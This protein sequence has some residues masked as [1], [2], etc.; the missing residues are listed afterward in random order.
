MGGLAQ[1]T[2]DV[3]DRELTHSPALG[4]VASSQAASMG[5]G[6]TT[7]TYDGGSNSIGHPTHVQLPFGTIDYTYDVRDRVATETRMLSAP[8]AIAG[9][10]QTVTRTYNV[11]GAPVTETWDDGTAWSYAYDAR[12]LLAGAYYGGTTLASYT[13][14][15]AGPPRYRTSTFDQRRDWSYDVLGRVTY[16]RIWRPTA[17][18]SWAERTYGFDGIGR[19][20]AIAGQVNGTT[21]DASYDYDLRDR[22]ISAQGPS[23]YGGTFTYSPAGNVNSATVSGA[24]DAPTRDVTYQYG[25]VDPQAV[26]ALVDAKTGSL[27]AS[28]QYDANGNLISRTGSGALSSVVSD[29]DDLIR[30]ASGPGGTETYFFGANAERMVAISP[31]EIKVWFGE[32]ETHYSLAGVQTLRWY[33]VA[34]GEPIARL[35]KT[36]SSISIELQYADALQNLIMSVTSTSQVSSSFLYGAFG[37]VVAQTGSGNHRR[38]F[39]GKEADATTG[40]RAYGYRSYDPLLLRWTAADPM[41]RFAPDAAW[42]QPQRAN[43]YAFSLN[44][45]VRYVDPDGRDPDSLVLRALEF[46]TKNGASASWFSYV[47]TYFSLNLVGLVAWHDVADEIHEGRALTNDVDHMGILGHVL[48]SMTSNLEKR[49]AALPWYPIKTDDKTGSVVIS[50]KEISDTE[51][52]HDKAASIANDA[53]ELRG[54]IH[55]IEAQYTSVTD[56]ALDDDGITRA[57][58]VEA[59]TVLEMSFSSSG[60]FLG[61]LKAMDQRASTVQSDARRKQYDAAYIVGYWYPD[62]F[63]PSDPCPAEPCP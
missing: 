54:Q 4:D 51:A 42:A 41:Y 1:N 23:A 7:T 63:S 30:R 24:L 20:D 29:G 8:S 46:L 43:L 60:G 16:D 50:D 49:D 14:S 59:L 15:V 33:H 37:E 61:A 25:A 32:S 11:I 31:T 47:H 45:P 34:G 55:D 18:T 48:S 53:S 17:G 3:I 28:M 22:L 13:R 57:S 2:Y 9:R 6:M 38:E 5:V 26:D 36:G 52:Y 40:L 39:N 12:G 62:W 19:L 35:E 58:S 56:A 27:V 10:T 21:A 44:N